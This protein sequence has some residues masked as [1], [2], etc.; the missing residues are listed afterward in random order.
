MFL[1][2]VVILIPRGQLQLY[3]RPSVRPSVRPQNIYSISM[4]VG[5]YVEVDEWCTVVC[6]MTRSKIKVKVTSRKSG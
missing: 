2:E 6:S 4:K 1:V 3:V 5:M